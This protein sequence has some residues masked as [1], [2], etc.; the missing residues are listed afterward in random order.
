MTEVHQVSV[1]RS[2]S[3]GARRDTR[4]KIPDRTPQGDRVHGWITLT[5]L[6][7]YAEY[8]IVEASEIAPIPTGLTFERATAIPA[9][10]F[11]ALDGLFLAGKLERG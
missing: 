10:L 11:T 4:E 3:D 8:A 5:R 7:G 1:T 9:A 2:R 6:G